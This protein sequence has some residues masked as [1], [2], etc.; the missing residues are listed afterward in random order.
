VPEAPDTIRSLVEQ[1]SGEAVKDFLRNLRHHVEV[2]RRLA[3]GEL[4]QKDVNAA[5]IRYAQREG[6]GY[7]DEIARLT[8]QYYRD[9][10]AV[11]ATFSE[12]FYDEI[13]QPSE[14]TTPAGD[15][16][17]TKRVSIEL[18]GL[19]G[20]EVVRR[21]TLENTGGE[22]MLVA[23]DLGACHGPDGESF[24]APLSVQPAQLAIAPGGS[25]QITL[26]LALLPSLFIPGNVYTT[27]VGVHG[28]EEL[29]FD[30]VIWA[31]DEVDLAAAVAPSAPDTVGSA[32]AEPEQAKANAKPEPVATAAARD[33][34]YVVR[35]PTCGRRFSRSKPNPRLNPH[36][37]PNG[38]PCPGR[39]GKLVKARAPKS[40]DRAGR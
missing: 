35:C 27:M 32:P 40:K 33:S 9:L 1:L 31:E 15:G 4:Q 19:P 20:R 28:H 39:Q 23:F 21:I 17:G 22:E 7:R 5:Y 14:W 16:D 6:K 29:A 12:Q 10:V 13:L 26:R 34:A 36:K 3:Q 38:E 18:H 11:G 8:A 2:Q 25:E 24:T 37:R 30:I